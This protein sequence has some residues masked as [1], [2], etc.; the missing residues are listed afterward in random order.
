LPKAFKFEESSQK[1]L[2]SVTLRNEPATSLG[3]REPPLS[4]QPRGRKE[5]RRTTKNTPADSH[6]GTVPNWALPAS[7]DMPV[8]TRHCAALLGRLQVGAHSN[9]CPRTAGMGNVRRAAGGA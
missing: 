6:C 7:G 8:K 9:T 2:D 3:L 5:P 4:I 1:L